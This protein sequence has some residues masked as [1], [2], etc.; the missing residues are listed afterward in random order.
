MKPIPKDRALIVWREYYVKGGRQTK[1]RTICEVLREIHRYSDDPLIKSKVEEANE[2]AKRM[3]AR[4][5]FYAVKKGGGK[6]V[7]LAIDALNRIHWWTKEAYK[8]A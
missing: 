8:D 7:H 3:Q 1:L 2:M 6:S 4:L 5:D